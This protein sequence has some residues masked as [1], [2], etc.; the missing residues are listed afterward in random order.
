MSLPTSLVEM[1]NQEVVIKPS[2]GLDDYNNGTFGDPVTA[3]CYISRQNKRTLDRT[4]REV[5]SGVQVILAQPELTVNVDDQLTLPD[6][7]QPPIIGIVAAPDENGD[8]YYLEIR[9]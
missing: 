5:V 7:S 8:P 3:K 6:G 4:G 9:A 1:M 2:T